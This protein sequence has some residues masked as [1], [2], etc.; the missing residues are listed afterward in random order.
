MKEIDSMLDA[1]LR[2]QSE[3]ALPGILMHVSIMMRNLS[4]H[5]CYHEKMSCQRPLELFL[6]AVYKMR[7]KIICV[8]YSGCLLPK[9]I[10]FVF[11]TKEFIFSFDGEPLLIIH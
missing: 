11:V 10:L 1:D 2:H 6:N 3:D 8:S 9:F 4:G 5:L 7:A